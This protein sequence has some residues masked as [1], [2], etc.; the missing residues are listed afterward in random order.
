MENQGWLKL[1]IVGL[2]LSAMA[3]G[4]FLL[5]NRLVSK[6]S[7]KS[8]GEVVTETTPIPSQGISVLGQTATPSATP[9]ATPIAVVTP[10]NPPAYT[11]IVQRTQSK[12]QT[13]PNTGIP[14]YLM[15]VG[16]LSAMV[17]GVSLSKFPN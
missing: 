14:V 15:G 11:R 8:Q 6:K 3:G 10:T 16:A 5:S 7:T 9:A 2:V 13:L 17:V 12:I 4:Y 1:V